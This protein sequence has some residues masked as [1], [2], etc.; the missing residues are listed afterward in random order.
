MEF[1]YNATQIYYFLCEVDQSFPV[2]LSDKQDLKAYAEKLLDKATICAVI[3]QG[4]IR[5]MVAG[6]TDHLSDGMAYISVV[7]TA[8]ECRGTGMAGNMLREFIT[9]CKNKHIK[10]VHLY[11]ARQNTGAIRMYEKMGFS[12]WWKCDESR[13]EDVHFVMYLK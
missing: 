9:I 4:K 13:P 10:A 1:R 11:T 12:I 2:P 5:S 8:E 6:Y 3:E 7:A